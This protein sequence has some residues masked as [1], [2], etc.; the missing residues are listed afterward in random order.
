[1]LEWTFQSAPTSTLEVPKISGAPMVLRTPGGA[2]AMPSMDRLY[3]LNRATRRWADVVCLGTIREWSMILIADSRLAAVHCR[4]TVGLVWS[5]EL[6]MGGKESR[7]TVSTLHHCTATTT[8]TGHPDCSFYQHQAW[9]TGQKCRD[10][11][12]CMS[13]NANWKIWGQH[14]RLI[15]FDLMTKY[16]EFSLRF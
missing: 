11:A 7:P 5:N 2:S 13:C 10:C 9:K 6:L 8:H 16:C 1:M 3:K 15:C 14:F 12:G 4:Q